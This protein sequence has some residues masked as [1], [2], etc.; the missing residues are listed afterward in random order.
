MTCLIVPSFPPAS[1][2]C[3]T[4]R[5]EPLCSAESKACWLNS[6]LLIGLDF[7][8]SFVPQTR[9]S[10]Y[11]GQISL[12]N[13]TLLSGYMAYRYASGISNDVRTL[14]ARA[15][16]KRNRR[17]T[18]SSTT[19]KP[20]DIHAVRCI[21][22]ARLRCLVR[23]IHSLGEHLRELARI[24][25]IWYASGLRIRQKLFCE[26]DLREFGEGARCRRSVA[27]NRASLDGSKGGLS[28]PSS[29]AGR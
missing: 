22:P 17:S 27:Q 6:F 7:V 20:S 19:P 10:R 18:I 16:P 13:F 29:T 24:S 28:W 21:P 14:L 26:N 3:R 23:Q 25:H 5:I 8:A 11:I 9:A 15:P 4:T 2:P 1:S 12:L